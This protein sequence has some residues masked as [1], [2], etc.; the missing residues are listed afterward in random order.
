M[1]SLSRDIAESQ[2]TKK[3][4]KINS[5]LTLRGPTG[6]IMSSESRDIAESK[7]TKKTYPPT[8]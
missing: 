8:L 2:K 4:K 6:R 7:K 1:S 3:T 5:H